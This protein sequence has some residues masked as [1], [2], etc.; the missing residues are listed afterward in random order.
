MSL[1][2]GEFGN[3]H[4]HREKLCDNE[5]RVRLILTLG[6]IKITDETPEGK[7]ASQASYGRNRQTHLCLSKLLFNNNKFIIYVH[8]VGINSPS[9]TDFT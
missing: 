6:N 8:F 2:K 5:N 1:Q 9:T 7:E 4:K 3:R